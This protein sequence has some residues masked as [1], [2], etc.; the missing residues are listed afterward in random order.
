MLKPLTTEDLAKAGNVNSCRICALMFSNL[1][2]WAEIHER[3]LM[4]DESVMSVVKWLNAQLKELEE[5]GNFH[6][7]GERDD[8]SFSGKK[9]ITRD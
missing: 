6:F 4:G 8:S 5:N 7:E 2:L 3:V 1:K 9:I